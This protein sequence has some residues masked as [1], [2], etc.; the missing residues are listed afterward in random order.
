MSCQNLNWSG[1]IKY[2]ASNADKVPESGGLYKV[3]RNDGVDGKLTRLYVGK[4]ANLRNQFNFH[5]SDNEENECIRENVRNK[6][7]YF[8]YAL[9]AGEDNRH[10]AENHLLETGKYECNTQGQ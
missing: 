3:L 6:E 4:A 8:Q 1:N 5:L 7:C 9:Q 10:A 2:L